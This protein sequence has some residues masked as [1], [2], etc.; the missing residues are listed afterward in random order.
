M[1]LLFRGTDLL[2][3]AWQLLGMRVQAM[4][5]ANYGKTNT[6][7]LLMRSRCTGR[8]ERS[9][10]DDE[11]VHAETRGCWSTERPEV[12]GL[13]DQVIRLN[14]WSTGLK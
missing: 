13:I 2:A 4:K 11:V 10:V 5:L 1:T 14:I 9:H 3:E 12:A 6:A 7:Q 8:L